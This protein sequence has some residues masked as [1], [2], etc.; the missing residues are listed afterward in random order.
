M[1]KSLLALSLAALIVLAWCWWSWNVVEYND[2]F[3]AIVKDCTDSTQNLFNVYQTD[4]SVDSILDTLNGCADICQSAQTKA[5]KLWDFDKDNSLK[6]AVVSLLSAEVEYLKKFW[7]SSRYW[8]MENIT[9]EDRVA[10]DWF[11][12]ELQELEDKLNNQFLLLQQ[13]Q[14]LFAAKHGL[15]LE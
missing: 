14:E 9:E 2:S 5:T 7:E 11:I 1:K 10:Y 13:A 6:D 3:V 8:N 15:K 12:N 4:S